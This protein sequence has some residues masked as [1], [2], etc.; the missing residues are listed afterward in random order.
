MKEST[1]TVGTCLSTIAT[2]GTAYLNGTGGYI[3]NNW[4]VFS[5]ISENL[6]V[7]SE[8]MIQ[9]VKVAVFEVTRD[10]K[11]KLTSTKF[12]KE[13]WVERKNGISIDL[14]VA[15]QLDKDFNPE[16]IVVKEIY[17]VTF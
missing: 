4:E 5:D 2:T 10:E 15:K 3:S 12:I 17:S 16:N 9:Q 11:G 14:V 6:T 7:R 8:P 13:L 1:V